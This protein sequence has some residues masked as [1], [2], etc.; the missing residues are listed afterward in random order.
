MRT[1]R[2]RNPLN[3]RR[4]LVMIAQNQTGLNN[5]FQLVSDSYQPENFYRY[6]R[7]DFEMLDKYN[8]GLIISSACMSGPLFEDFWKNRDKS[9]DHVLQRCET[10][11]PSSKKSLATGSTA[12]SSG[13]TSRNS[14]RATTLSSKPVWKW[15]LRLS[16]QPTATTHDQNSGKTE[17]CTS[18]SAGA[19][20]SQSGL[21]LIVLLPASV[22][23]V[24]YELYPKNGDQMWE[25]Y[26]KYSGKHNI[27]Y[28]DTFI[29]DSIE[30][31]HHIAF[32]RCEDFL[33]DST[34][35]LPEF[36]VPEGKTAIQALT[37]DALAGMKKKTSQT[38]SM[39]T[40]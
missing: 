24:G 30:R 14:T 4:H 12:K 7:M 16:A 11:L 38:P 2:K 8:E 18:A 27:E 6:P 3:N 31:T 40:A 39:L 32:D 26:K 17:R 19:A 23:E 34:V 5:L 35:R 33:P 20:R 15:V 13:T 28:D 36:V 9:A 29:R 22:D 10:R 21:T 25:S 37:S 1:A